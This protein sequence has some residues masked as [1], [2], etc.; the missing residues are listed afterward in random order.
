MKYGVSPVSP[1]GGF[2]VTPHALPR[3]SPI[4]AQVKRARDRR[5]RVS[6]R[7]KPVWQA[8]ASQ[9]SMGHAA[10]SQSNGFVYAM[11]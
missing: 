8:C 2:G 10:N 4:W 11:F 6:L 5:G 7:G 1:L 9:C 3:P